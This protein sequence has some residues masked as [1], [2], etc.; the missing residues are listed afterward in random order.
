MVPSLEKETLEDK[1]EL[2]KLQDELSVKRNTLESYQNM[3]Q[4]PIG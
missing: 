3:L 4:T 1:K 2:V